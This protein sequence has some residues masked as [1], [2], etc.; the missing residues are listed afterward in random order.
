MKNRKNINTTT[1][2]TTTKYTNITNIVAP[3]GK[4]NQTE[5]PEFIALCKQTQAELKAYL[6]QKLIEAGY[7]EVIVDNG[8]IYAKGITPILLTAHLDTVHKE[9]VK[10]FY[11]RIENGNHIISSPQ[12]IGGDDRCGV[13]MILEIIKE[14]KPFIL[15]CEDEEIGGVGS[16]KFC[17]TE[18]IKELSELNY[19]IELDRANRNDAVFY[20]CDN[21]E[22]TKFITETTGYKEAWGSFS[23][24]SNLAP[25]CKVAAVNFS[26]GYYH[27]HTTQEEVN[28]EEMLRT[29]EAV[30]KLLTTESKQFVYIEV[31]NYY[32]YG[33]TNYNWYGGYND[34][35]YGTTKRSWYNDNYILYVTFLNPDT[36]VEC[37]KEYYGETEEACWVDFFMANPDVSFNM[38]LDFNVDYF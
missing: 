3:K 33:R 21:P 15:L 27:A 34:S 23:D 2:Y 25:A 24:I 19:L 32:R 8:F 35:F 4:K 20:D 10:D 11:E 37:E 13:Y 5:F 6:P 22:F 36:G 17:K 26:C 18:F 9:T 29:I 30:K 31:D 12:G 14:H 28:V 16:S 38:V 1:K 7:T